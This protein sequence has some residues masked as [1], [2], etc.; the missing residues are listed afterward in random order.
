MDPTH[1]DPEF[2][3][4]PV[5]ETVL[6]VQFQP[7]TRLNVAH[8]GLYWDLIR[9]AYP[10]V[11]QR[12]ALEP[13]ME[14]F[15]AAPVVSG[16]K[17]KLSGRPEMPRTWFI[18]D[19]S[20]SGQQLIQ[21]QQDRFLQNWRRGSLSSQDYPRYSMNREQFGENFEQF[22]TF[23]NRE[24]L[25]DVLANQCEVTYVNHIMPRDG[26]TIAELVQRCFD[27][28]MPSPSDDFLPSVPE[29]VGTRFAYRLPDNRGRLRVS[30]NPGVH[31]RESRQFL[32]FR[33]TARGAPETP[34]TD[35]VMAWL[36]LG[37]HWVVCA[38]K[39][40]TTSALHEQWG[41]VD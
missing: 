7:L 12:S 11:E 3:R 41:L 9:G 30:L 31:L 33:L 25:G 40:L 27:G 13:D 1:R 38:F 20:P 32:D 24:K 29:S 18:A 23:A 10:S 22:L 19:D 34:T 35:G 5:I 4:P 2:R 28:I 39:S 15:D 16:L 26:E 37:H 6:G 36:D 17:W 8:V 21:L 14:A